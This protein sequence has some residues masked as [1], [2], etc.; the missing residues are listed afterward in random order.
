MAKVSLA[1]TTSNSG[2]FKQDMA[3]SHVAG[4]SSSSH[5]DQASILRMYRVVG[6]P[7]L[8]WLPAWCSSHSA[9]AQ[10]ESSIG[11]SPPNYILLFSRSMCCRGR[12]WGDPDPAKLDTTYIR[13]LSTMWAWR[14]LIVPVHHTPILLVAPSSLNKSR[15][16]GHLRRVQKQ[17]RLSEHRRAR[18]RLTVCDVTTMR[19]FRR[20][21]G[22]PHQGRLYCAPSLANET[23][24]VRRTE[25]LF[26]A[27][28][29]AVLRSCQ[30]KLWERRVKVPMVDCLSNPGSRKQLK[31]PL[32]HSRSHPFV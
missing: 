27:L 20:P 7:T 31:Q 15:A 29:L 8:K 5:N 22:N 14:Q 9:R 19:S 21:K 11:S 18:L 3:G 23:R 28:L 10:G 1:R 26:E 24:L 32:R 2:R 12:V 30:H 17:Q 16:T 13:A 6:Y 25:A 4:P